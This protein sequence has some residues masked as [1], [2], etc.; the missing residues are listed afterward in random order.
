MQLPEIIRE[1]SKRF[2]MIPFEHRHISA[3]VECDHRITALYVE[4]NT[5]RKEYEK[6]CRMIDQSISILQE[7]IIRGYKE[8]L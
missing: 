4:K 7:S 5:A 1:N 6:K 2:N 8:Q 3:M